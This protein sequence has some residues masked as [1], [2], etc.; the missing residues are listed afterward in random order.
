MT[1]EPTWINLIDAGCFLS[2]VNS[3]DKM[4]SRNLDVFTG[5]L[6]TKR[7]QIKI[8]S[9]S[10]THLNFAK[11]PILSGTSG[12]S[13]EVSREYMRVQQ[14]T[15]IE[16]IHDMI[17]RVGMSIGVDESLIK[18]V[19]MAESG[20]DVMARSKVGASGLMQIMPFTAMKIALEL[21]D[22]R[23]SIEKVNTPI[24]NVFY[25]TFYL[26]KL[27]KYY[28]NHLVAAIAAYNAGPY[29]TNRWIENCRDCREDIFVDSIPFKETRD[30]IKR[31]VTLYAIFQKKTPEIQDFS[32]QYNLAKIQFSGLPP[33]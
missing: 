2:L 10:L 7:Y 9:N 31:V 24:E 15:R 32:P 1:I 27:L 18:A 6:N 13:S 22:D 19:I 14:R 29:W 23:F 30:Y 3:S 25:G 33:F 20:F 16:L 5:S 11:N 12:I 28:D 17:G 4:I 8:S 26:K 21:N